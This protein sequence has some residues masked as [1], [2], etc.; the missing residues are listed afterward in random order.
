MNDKP[1]RYLV[2]MTTLRGTFYMCGSVNEGIVGWTSNMRSMA[3]TRYQ[4][5]PAAKRAAQGRFGQL[6]KLFDVLSVKVVTEEHVEPVWQ[7]QGSRD[8]LT[9]EPRAELHRAEAA[10]AKLAAV[11]V[12]AIEFLL[13][14]EA[15]YEHR[16]LAANEIRLWLAQSE[17]QP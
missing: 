7:A 1:P 8:D 14:P 6:N 13:A 9:E 3:V 11:P 10:E 5:L 16:D 4:S 12:A 15:R 2:Q 17:V